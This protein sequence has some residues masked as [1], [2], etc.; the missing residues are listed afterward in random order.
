MFW[1]PIV[2]GGGGPTSRSRALPL[3]SEKVG[4][5]GALTHE[6]G[7][8]SVV[9]YRGRERARYGARVRPLLG[10]APP[11]LQIAALFGGFRKAAAEP[12]RGSRSHRICHRLHPAGRL[13]EDAR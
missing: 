7:L 6:C 5:R 3:K 1:P 10:R 2:R 4:L 9:V 11:R 12:R 13:C 8:A